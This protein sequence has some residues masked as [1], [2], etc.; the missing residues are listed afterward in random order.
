MK[1]IEPS[2][3]S[4]RVAGT[5]RSPVKGASFLTVAWCPLRRNGIL[6]GG[7]CW[8]STVLKPA[9]GDHSSQSTYHIIRSVTKQAGLTMG[10]RPSPPTVS[11]S[12]LHNFGSV[13]PPVFYYR[14]PWPPT[15]GRRA[16]TLAL[17]VATGVALGVT[18]G[19]GVAEGVGLTLGDSEGDTLGL[20]VGQCCTRVFS[21]YWS[22]PDVSWWVVANAAPPTKVNAKTDPAIR[23][24]FMREPFFLCFPSIAHYTP[25]V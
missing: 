8:P 10:A 12:N 24:R 7:L 6:C 1:Y 23:T 15:E 21:W 5:Q 11:R 14:V 19:V 18:L 22:Q 3:G 13:N 25:Y 16:G 9:M 20:G 17:G 4:C 2:A